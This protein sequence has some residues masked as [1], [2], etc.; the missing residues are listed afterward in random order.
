MLN[1]PFQ[2]SSSDLLQEISSDLTFYRLL[3]DCY[4]SRTTPISP[5]N[6]IYIWYVNHA[7]NKSLLLVAGLRYLGNQQQTSLLS[8]GKRDF[9]RFPVRSQQSSPPPPPP[10]PLWFFIAVPP[11]NVAF[12]TARPADLVRRVTGGG[13]RPACPLVPEPPR[14]PPGVDPAT[15]PSRP[16]QPGRCR[17]GYVNFFHGSVGMKWDN[18]ICKC[19]F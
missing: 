2:N 1:Y 13:T 10:P 18:V 3:V 4:R 19:F 9:L 8:H 15:S 5:L 14:P 12:V 17:F 7:L 6:D 16:S 11:V